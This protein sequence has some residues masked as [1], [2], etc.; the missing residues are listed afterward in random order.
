MHG[1]TSP[2]MFKPFQQYV[3]LKKK[4]CY[5]IFWH[6]LT[7][8]YTNNLSLL[9]GKQEIL[10]LLRTQIHIFTLVYKFIFSLWFP[11]WK[12]W[13]FSWLG[14]RNS[15][16][17]PVSIMESG[18]YSSLWNGNWNFSNL[19]NETREFFRFTNLNFS[20]HF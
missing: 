3:R 13:K 7:Y 8:G 12:P 19:R 16:I 18:S 2:L 5:E 1:N 9:H 10:N 11:E 6:L 15:E 14:E 20:G 4:Q 17:F